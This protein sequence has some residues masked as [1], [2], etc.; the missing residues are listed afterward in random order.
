MTPAKRAFDV[1]ASAAGLLLMAPLFAVVALL[2]RGYDG[3]PVFFRQQRVGRRGVPFRIWKFRTMAAGAEHAGPQVTAADDVRVT[4]VGGWLR[5][6]K[7]DE[8]PQLINVLAGQMS[9]VGPRP[10]VPR[11]VAMYS[12]DQRALLDYVPGL[13]DPASIAYRGEGELLAGLP[14][15]DR[16]YAERI[17]PDKARLSLEYARRATMATDLRLIA[18]T[19]LA[20][21]RVPVSL[22]PPHPGAN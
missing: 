15:P 9:I 13:T 6:F 5:R 16:V 11:F 18:V 2:V 12:P 3:G 21:G 8:L 14:D 1:A 19:L 4:S 17:M 10:E 7:L 22:H 20:V